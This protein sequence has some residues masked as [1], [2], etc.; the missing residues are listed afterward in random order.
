MIV[1]GI[2][3]LLAAAGLVWAMNQPSGA[4]L[5][6]EKIYSKLVIPLAKVLIFLGFGLLAGQA[7]ESLGWTKRIARTVRPMTRWGHLSDESGAAFVSSFV[8]GLVANSMLMG[9]YQEKK[10][11]RK[12]LV[13]TYLL[14]NGLPVYIVHFPTTFVVV[15][16][17]AGRAGVIYL[18]ITFVAACLRSMCVLIYTRLALP[19][20][21]PMWSA[22]VDHL[23]PQEESVW[24]RIWKRFKDRFSRLVLYTVP[25]YVLI[26]LA[27]EWGLFHWLKGRSVS[28]VSSDLF[29]VE[30]A[31]VIIVALAAEF[32]SG[33]AA[34]GALQAAG[35]LEPKQVVVALIVGT[36]IS[37]PLRA[38]RHQLP[39]Y[40]GLFNLGLGSE[41]LFMSQTMRILSL[42]LVTAVYALWG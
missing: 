40:A 24:G 41:L 27:G 1:P 5:S 33:M 22:L 23:D 26:F 4:A 10:I 18:A 38:V 37:T 19:R 28:W 31:G 16:S 6:V 32:S 29:P 8:S 21:Q 2:L 12:E 42:M 14:N 11:T 39:A 25:I 7:L 35:S 20:P 17:L 34:A 3:L 13:L 30:V 36:I 9:F 15:A